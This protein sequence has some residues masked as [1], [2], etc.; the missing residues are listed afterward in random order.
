MT[1]K[2]IKATIQ[3]HRGLAATWA[4]NNPILAYGEPGFEKDTYKLKIGD[5]VTEWNSLEYFND[6]YAKVR[7]DNEFN[8]PDDFIPDRYEICFADT[9]SKGLRAKLGDGITQWQDLPYID[10]HIY[11]E[12][13]QLII[14][15]YYKN[16]KFYTDGT[17]TTECPA[18]LNTLYI[19]VPHSE[20]YIYNG[21][22]YIPIQTGSIPPAS[23][24]VAGI[25]KLYPST[26]QN[27]DGTMT[28]KAITDELNQK[29]SSAIVDIDNELLFLF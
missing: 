21:N 23:S 7:R 1:K 14:S 26:G 5:G 8:Y 16:D 27:T 28:Q 24:S 10:D 11:E 29:A 25:M 4:K 3:L 22:N 15:G 13:S 6:D 19:D 20:I 9:V 17:Y 18:I 2:V 12:L